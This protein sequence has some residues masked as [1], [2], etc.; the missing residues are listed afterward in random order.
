MAGDLDAYLTFGDGTF[1]KGGKPLHVYGETK[2][3]FENDFG[4]IQ[5][6]RYDMGFEQDLRSTEEWKPGDD[7][8]AA[9]DPKFDPV[10]ITKVVDVST[11]DLLNAVYVG[12]VFDYV[13]IWQKKAGTSRERSGGYFFKIELETVNIASLKWSAS[14]GGPPEETLSLEFR[15]IRLEYLPQLASGALDQTRAKTTS[16]PLKA[17]TD[18]LRL[19]TPHN[20]QNK[21]KNGATVTSSDKSDI[22]NQVLAAL[23]KSN[24]GLKIK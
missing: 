10:S 23:K 17:E 5:I 8:S 9:H 1:G 21:E 15:G 3:V 16:N 20:K 18:W 12:A 13:W 22:V 14:E 19:P 7:D 11:P 24:P 4:S 6:K 2:D